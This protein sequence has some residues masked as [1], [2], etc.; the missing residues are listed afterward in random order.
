M[1]RLVCFSHPS[2]L[3]YLGSEWDFFTG[4]DPTHG[5]VAYQTRGNSRDL[6]YV[7]EDG[8]AVLRV[9]NEGNVPVGGNRRS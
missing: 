1:G 2:V 5:N 8:T 7:D 3:S 9:D 6:A 4:P